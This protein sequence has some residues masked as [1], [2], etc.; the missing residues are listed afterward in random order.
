M[1]VLHSDPH[2][3]QTLLSL[4]SN[5][6][7]SLRPHS[8]CRVSI[9]RCPKPGLQAFGV[10]PKSLGCLSQSPGAGFGGC[11]ERSGLWQLSGEFQFPPASCTLYFCFP[12]HKGK[13]SKLGRSPGLVQ[14]HLHGT[15]RMAGDL[16]VPHRS[17]LLSPTSFP[18]STAMAGRARSLP[19]QRDTRD[20]AV[21]AWCSG[22]Q[23]CGPQS[24]GVARSPSPSVQGQV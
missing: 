22:P 11:G 10:G 1:E 2:G 16:P 5:R 4:L 14:D 23:D 17:P 6:G 24:Y 13:Q 8:M 9:W 20:A 18:F 19:A 21:R 7:S 12:L 3:E 15:V